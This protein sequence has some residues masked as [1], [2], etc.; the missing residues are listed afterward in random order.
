M[1]SSK[2]SCHVIFSV[3]FLMTN[4]AW[5]RIPLKVGSYIMP[6][7]IAW[8]GVGIVANL[9]AI[10][11]LGR[12]FISA[13][14]SDAYWIGSFRRSKPVTTICVEVGQFGFNLF[15]HLKIH[16]IRRGARRAWL[17]VY[18]TAWT[19]TGQPFIRRFWIW[20]HEVRYGISI[21]VPKH[22]VVSRFMSRFNAMIIFFFFFN[23]FLFYRTGFFHF[24]TKIV[25]MTA[26]S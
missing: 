4:F 8:V 3:K 6:V 2:V 13:K 11:V 7:E 21:S 19:G 14:A 23:M 26:V 15:L 9:T 17:R 24:T 12:S 16:Q 1:N 18:T 5:I 20:V 22:L 10:G 25:T